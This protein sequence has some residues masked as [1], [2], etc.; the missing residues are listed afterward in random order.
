MAP[1]EGFDRVDLELIHALHVDGRAPFTKIAGVL[2]VSDQTV[3]RRY[4]R[5]RALDAIRVV[6]RTYPGAVGETSWFVRI[7]CS[8]QETEHIGRAIAR[9]P[10]AS[11]VKLTSGGT[12]IVAVVRAPVDQDSQ[13]LLLQELPRTRHVIEVTANC[14]LHMFFGGPDGPVHVLGDDQIA[15]LGIPARGGTTTV[16]LDAVDRRILALLAVDGRA[17]ITDLART[18]G[19]PPTTIRRRLAELRDSG[20]LYFDVDVDHRRLRLMT[21]AL[22]WMTV[23]PRDLMAA[24][25]QLAEHSEVAFVAA[26]TGATNLYASVLC[27][28]APELFAYLTSKVAAVPSLQ[29]VETAPVIRTLKTV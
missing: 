14:M 28:G 7:R 13:T 12:E 3:A 17:E 23:S 11:W 18:A 8:P 16:E 4:S 24:G 21:Q 1:A 26:T 5:L 20:V 19:I 6:G 2:G 22:L 9:R 10:E 27:A 29:A 15:A 25:R